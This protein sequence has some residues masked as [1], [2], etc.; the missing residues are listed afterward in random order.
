MSQQHLFVGTT[1]GLFC[2]TSDASRQQ[3]TMAEPMLPGWEV[4]SVGL[5]NGRE[6][7]RLIV[8][9]THYAYGATLRVSDDMGKTWSQIE[10]GP[11]YSAESGFKMNRI[12]QVCAHPAQHHTVFAG[13]D[14]AGLFVSRDG[15]D[16]WT[17]IDS[18]TKHPTRPKWF[19]GGGGLCLH[20][21]IVDH[22]DPQR[23]WVGISA[24]GCFRTT[25][26]G[27]TWTPANKGLGGVPTGSDE[28]D[29]VHCVH[30]MVQHAT[31]PDT[32][33][34]QYHGGVYRTDDAG[35]NWRKI[36]HGLPGN[37]GFPMVMTNRGEL[38][39]A[40]L[41]GDETR[42]FK[43]GRFA[44]YRSTD[45]GSSWAAT[46]DGLP[47]GS[48]VGILRD[49]MTVD[50]R[51]EPGVYLGTTMGHVYASRDGGKAWQRLPGDVP[52]VLSVRTCQIG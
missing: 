6:T 30:K 23:M 3:W 26:G 45:E 36:E 52:R 14:E 10:R 19:A 9:T 38:C 7:P 18:L 1:K 11:A 20:T 12:W 46:N 50:D 49:A 47:A 31:K 21:I 4:S 41:G 44:I 39:I 33:F 43:D 25:D 16:S 32:L 51:D 2:Y 13:V 15:G 37:F 29:A 34:M 28:P 40:P 22:S 24:V 8:G 5:V 35:D 27:A 42:F 17:E 48:Y